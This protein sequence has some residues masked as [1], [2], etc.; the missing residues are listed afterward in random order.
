MS[1]ELKKEWTGQLGCQFCG[2]EETDEHLIS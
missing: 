1:Y 2:K